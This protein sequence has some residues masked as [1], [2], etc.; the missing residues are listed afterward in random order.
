Q[1]KQKLQELEAR[2]SEPIAIVSMA[3]RLPGG[4]CT[5]EQLWELVDGGLDAITPLPGD[6]GWP[7][8][9]LY[10]PDRDKPGTTYTRGGGFIDHPGMFDA[11]FFGISPRE[12]AS[13]DPQQR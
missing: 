9:S 11:A 1:T 6:R 10:H 5:P 4:V 13:I 8:E 12:A 7:L 3:C 2:R